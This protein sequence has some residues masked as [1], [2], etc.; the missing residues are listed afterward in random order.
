M[1]DIVSSVAGWGFLIFLVLACIFAISINDNRLD[2]TR[3]IE[4]TL[5]K[6]AQKIAGLG[7]VAVDPKFAGNRP[8]VDEDFKTLLKVAAHYEKKAQDLNYTRIYGS[9][10]VRLKISWRRGRE[11]EKTSAEVLTK[12]EAKTNAEAVTIEGKPSAETATMAAGA[13][14]QPRAESSKVGIADYFHANSDTTNVMIIGM[15]ACAIAVSA[16]K[17]LA[18]TKLPSHPAETIF[19][20]LTVFDIALGMLTGLLTTFVVK[21]GSNALSNTSIG[22]VDVSNPYGIAFVAA[23]VGL[24]TEK[25]YS[26][27]QP[28][29]TTAKTIG[30]Q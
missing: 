20:S 26:W 5:Q 13:E 3:F 21:S 2:E 1:W 9:R 15:S 16:T 8:E 25:F 22:T 12:A 17:L 7:R 11:A 10:D 24:F 30:P 27:L 18:A 14:E 4:Q 29:V 28:I 6:N 23:V 19:F